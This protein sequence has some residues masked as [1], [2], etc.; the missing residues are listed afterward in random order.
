MK[1]STVSTLAQLAEL[2]GVSVATVSRSL[3]G[4]TVI[5]EATRSRIVALAQEHG[6]Q[7]NQAARNLRLRRTGAIGVVLPLGHEADQTL[8]D[9]FFMS[10][11]G[12][13]ADAI[14][15]RGHD[16]LLSRVI[17]TDDRWLDRIVDAG[18]V[19]GVVLIGQ[20]NQIEVIERVAQRYRPMIVWGA[21]QPGSEQITVGSDN[22]AGGRMAAEHLLAQ[23]RKR[24]AFFGN[25]EVPEFAARF[26]GFSQALG[27]AGHGAG[28]LLPLHLTSESSYGAIEAYLGKN[29]PPDGIVAA[30][31]VIAMSALRALAVH[32]KRVPQDVGVI[33]YDDV[34]VASHT[35]P[36]LT[37][38]RQDVARGAEMM[39]QMLFSRMEGG[40]VASVS[41]MPEL[42]LRGSA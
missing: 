10:L 17:P 41:M 26:A 9:P 6:F 18:R 29:P 39:I 11:L 33:G 36:P 31:D 40:E 34:M 4:N 20:S 14:A 3:A 1:L 15:G 25:V 5:A 8:S 37:T 30:S 7:V 22:V 21:D 2:A 13:L 16:L 23:G 32:G 35:T 42:I 24:L 28:T 38:I 19:D 12:P 27:A